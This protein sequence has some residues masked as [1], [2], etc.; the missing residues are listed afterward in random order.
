MTL[1]KKN[2]HSLR[3]SFFSFLDLTLA[4]VDKKTYPNLQIKSLHLES[5]FSGSFWQQKKGSQMHCRFF[6]WTN[7]WCCFNC[8]QFPKVPR[9][10]AVVLKSF[11]LK[12]FEKSCTLFLNFHVFVNVAEAASLFV[13]QFSDTSELSHF[14]N[15]FFPEISCCVSYTDRIKT[16]PKLQMLNLTISVFRF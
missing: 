8:P 3:R 4:L 9:R 14:G 6:V 1:K 11:Q 2:P 12:T 15:A 10:C 13:M 7:F 16:S 5:V